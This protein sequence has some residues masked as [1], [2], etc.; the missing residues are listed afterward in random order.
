[1]SVNNH[2]INSISTTPINKPPLAKAIRHSDDYSNTPTSS[3]SSIV[4]SSFVQNYNK[5][6]LTHKKSSD[7]SKE[8]ADAFITLRNQRLTRRG[9]LKSSAQQK[10][11]KKRNLSVTL[12]MV[13]MAVI[14]NICWAP[15]FIFPFFYANTEESYKTYKVIVQLIGYS[16]CIWNPIILIIKSKRF[17]IQLHKVKMSFKSL[18]KSL[19]NGVSQTAANSN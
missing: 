17:K 12:T 4:E 6:T 19:V 13:L 11:I 16:S 3:T 8:A 2:S 15:F 1:M 7:T 14:F 5:R 9:S 10:I 18:F